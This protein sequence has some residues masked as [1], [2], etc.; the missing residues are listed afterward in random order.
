M[1]EYYIM[2]IYCSTKNMVT[3]QNILFYG[4]STTRMISAHHIYIVSAQEM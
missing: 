4:L 3:A 2:Q 1:I